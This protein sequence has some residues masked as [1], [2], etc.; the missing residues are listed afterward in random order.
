MESA[1]RIGDVRSVERY[2]HALEDYT[3]SEPLPYTRFFADRGRIL[4]RY[5]S[6]DRQPNTIASLRRLHKEAI[7]VGHRSA[8]RALARALMAQAAI[9]SDDER[10]S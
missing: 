5:Q 4:A 1:L 8:A 6:G 10:T 3:R 7:E 2:A 9:A